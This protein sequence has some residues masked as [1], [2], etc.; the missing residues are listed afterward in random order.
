MRRLGVMSA[1]VVALG[2][3]DREAS[4]WL[5]LAVDPAE[6]IELDAARVTP[7][8]ALI[9]RRHE[10]RRLAI[11]L[12]RTPNAVVVRAPGACPL[13]LTPAELAAGTTLERRLDALF[14]FGPSA[15][16][17][18]FGERF[19]L[20]AVP[21]C[22]EAARA[23]VEMTPAGGAPLDELSSSESGRVLA[24]RT[25]P[26]D[27]LGAPEFGIV[28]V[29]AR[30]RAATQI[31]ARLLLEDGSHV[32]RELEV[33]AG[34]RASGLPNVAVDHAVLLAGA[35]PKLVARPEGSRAELVARG[36]LA[37]LVPDRPG[38]YG[39]ADASG[40][41]LNL[42]AGLYDETPLDCGRSDCHHALAESSQ[43]SPMTSALAADL[44][45]RHPVTD[46][47][48]ALLCHATGEPG[49]NDGGFT[50]VFAELGAHGGLP[51]KYSDLPRALRRLSGVGCLACHGPGAIPEA[52]ARWA[53]LRSDVCAVCHDA[54]PRY[55]HVAALATTRMA[56]ADHDVRQREN[57]TCARCHTTWGALG[58]PERKPPT[59][60]GT[61]GIGCA[62]CH[63]VHP[64]GETAS[65]TV[66][67]ALLRAMPIPSLLAAPS[68]AVRGPSRVC[69]TCHAPDGDQPSAS[70][71]AIWAGRGGVEPETGVALV[72]SA[73]HAKETRGCLGCHG[74]GP[75]SLSLGKGHAFQA[76]STT[77]ARC[78][79]DAVARSPALAA[80][81]RALF[82][83]L[84]PERAR[85]ASTEPPHA[86]PPRQPLSVARQRA[87][88][89]TLL[90][91]EDPAADVH[92]QPYATLLLDRAE[93]ALASTQA[94][95]AP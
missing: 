59:E 67:A 20:R 65:P 72:G 94:R 5:L 62:A 55:G 9:E 44:G 12:D 42:N 26:I 79:D 82:A 52:S 74:A 75:D 36:G 84:T 8:P 61:L 81:A 1:L 7:A 18:G 35:S 23:R 3:R 49:R 24:G 27:T 43:A 93:H 11:R 17:V 63:D 31:R 92:N 88:R 37:E 69:F 2:C 56:H 76:P 60:A 40:R 66:S 10:S 48:C 86:L 83:K 89:D 71:A 57:P 80:R 19:E 46:P 39:V 47:T 53:V 70:A 32:E 87:L 38:S 77:C 28:P 51:E 22:P 14:D 78:H 85:S 90:V 64:H 54:P 13:T 21:R 25:R 4:V 68:A 29:S 50:S 45:G 16:V 15:R 91:L 33:L 95:G 41:K 30:R 34:T 73:P 58:R 6:R